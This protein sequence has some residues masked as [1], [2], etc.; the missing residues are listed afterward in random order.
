MRHRPTN[1]NDHHKRLVTFPGGFAF[2]QNLFIPVGCSF[3]GTL[4]VWGAGVLLFRW[5]IWATFVIGFIPPAL[6]IIIVQA[7]FNNKPPRF[8]YHLFALLVAGNEMRPL[9]KQPEH[10]LS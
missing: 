1:D 2:E 7:F 8:V 10:P 4:V 3:L 5:N 6:T 9:K